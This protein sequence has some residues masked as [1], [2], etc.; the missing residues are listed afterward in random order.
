[1]GW[2]NDGR[3]QLPQMLLRHSGNQLLRLLQQT[4]K[5]APSQL[6]ASQ[7]Q[8]PQQV[9]FSPPYGSAMSTSLCS[10]LAKYFR[11][12]DLR[13]PPQ[14]AGNV[15]MQGSV[16][17]DPLAGGL[18]QWSHVTGEHCKP[19]IILQISF[20][21]STTWRICRRV[22]DHGTPGVVACR[23]FCKVSDWCISELI[24]IGFF[25]TCSSRSSEGFRQI[26]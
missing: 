1:M 19:S 17:S 15:L 20:C 13:S 7:M 24:C 23:G 2:T 22:A 21:T 25:Q 9:I 14:M 10:V 4:A 6:C 16:A 12:L 26:A 18:C 11:T 5:Q 3:L 8:S